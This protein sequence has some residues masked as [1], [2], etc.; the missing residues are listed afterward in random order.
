MI[1]QRAMFTDKKF[2][3]I[4]ELRIDGK[5]IDKTKT[6]DYEVWYNRITDEVYALNG[7]SEIEIK[8]KVGNSYDKNSL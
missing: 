1:N 7:F 5:I 6:D 4:C 2:L 3:Y 8:I